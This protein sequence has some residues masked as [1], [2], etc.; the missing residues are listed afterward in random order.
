MKSD[1]CFTNKLYFESMKEKGINL[2]KYAIIKS[3]VTGDMGAFIA[4]SYGV[5]T[6]EV[7][8]GFKNIADLQNEWDKTGEYKYAWI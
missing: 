5:K 4:K 2:E 7:L 1:R 3:I 6:F 8:T